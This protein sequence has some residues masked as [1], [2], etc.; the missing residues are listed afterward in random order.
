[1]GKRPN[2]ILVLTDDQGY[3]DL[4]CHG[5]PIIQ[6]PNLDSFHDE[7]VRFTN[8][9]VG[10]TCAPTRAGLLT[11]HYANSTG[12]WHTFSGRSLLRK[13]EWTLASALGENGYRTGIFGKWH[14]GDTYP[15]RPIDRGFQ[16]SITHGGGGISQIPDYWGNDYFDDTYRVKDELKE[17]EGY[18]T[19]VFFNEGLKFI[20]KNKNNEFFCYIACNAPHTPLNVDPDYYEMYRGKTDDKKARFYGMI[21]N[22]DENFG[23]LRQKLKEWDL[24]DNTILMFMTDNGSDSGID[25]DKNHYVTSGYNAGLRGKKNSEYDGGHRVPFFFNWPG[26]NIIKGRDI[27]RPA[28]NVDF[29]PT[30]LD[31]CGIEAKEGVSFHGKSL[32]PLLKGERHWEDRAIVTDSQ[33]HPTPKKWHKS[34]VMTQ[35]WRLINGCELYDMTVDRGQKNN[36]SK[37]KPDIVNK[38]RKEYDK[39][40]EIVSRQYDDMI[41][42]HIGKNPI[43]LLGQ[44]MR[45]DECVAAWGQHLVRSGLIALGYWEISVEEAGE[46]E[47]DMRR[48]PSSH[49]RSLAE[50]IEP[51]KDNVIINWNG[52]WEKD[53]HRYTGG[54]AIPISR[55]S[56][57]IQGIHEEREIDGGDVSVI[58]TIKLE[59]GE[60]LLRASFGNNEKKE[61][62]SPYFIYVRK[63]N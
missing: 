61:L 39:W 7:S 34:A 37:E 2:I 12:V 26:G 47:F 57:D 46:Y 4:G 38:L 59:P 29:M 6:T 13:N 53:R 31:I 42:L 14:L 33:R 49:E 11:G 40:W 56:I 20:E 1:M 52:I 54:K 10:P 25:I 50:G 19:D 3:G 24:E 62:L 32:F 36:I 60:C 21:T 27:D 18:C 9:H 23:I 45:N 41:P 5:N 28:A 17:F 43:A 16:E 8:Y 22:I 51:G 44:D 30:L 15:Y 55:A 63:V 35:R 48:W 58:F